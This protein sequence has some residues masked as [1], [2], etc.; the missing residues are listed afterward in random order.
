M[1]HEIYVVDFLTFLRLYDYVLHI[2]D[3]S[4]KSANWTASFQ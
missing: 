3:A 4:S 2:F 1:M